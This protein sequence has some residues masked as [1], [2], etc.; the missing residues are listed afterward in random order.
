MS[1]I[2]TIGSNYVLKRA[3]TLGWLAIGLMFILLPVGIIDLVV[4]KSPMTLIVVAIALIIHI[5]NVLLLREQ[6]VKSWMLS[7]SF[8]DTLLITFLNFNAG[9]F[10][11]YNVLIYSF[12]VIAT[13]FILSD[14]WAI[15][16]VA[17]FAM[18]CNLVVGLLQMNGVITA[19]P[20]MQ[21]I[22]A[23]TS[24]SYQAFALVVV[25]ILL[26]ALGVF[27]TMFTRLVAQREQELKLA[28]DQAKQQSLEQAALTERLAESNDQLQ[29][30][31][32]M[33]QQTV[34]ALTVTA[35]PIA[36]GVL[37]LPL[38][39]A[40]DQARANAVRRSLFKTIDH[41]RAH[42]VI[43]DLTGVAQASPTFLTLIEQL[44]SGIRLL[45]ADVIIAGMQPA[46]ARSFVKLHDRSV[47]IVSA[48]TIAAALK[49]IQTV[50]SV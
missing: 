36:D 49:H 8:V 47:P 23:T 5:L 27:T 4:S 10:I 32:A 50:T 9:G 11:S 33:L 13:S 15:M 41:Q 6:T 30:T 22:F 1:D 26:I 34:E 46:L 48:P 37:V 44:V 21:A 31:Q 12:V 29:N 17:I 2:Q 19:S 43:L 42:T 38:I 24:P 16:A 35:L 7:V 18:V 20:K 39:G 40:F 25:S 45:G 3:R 14:V 28:R